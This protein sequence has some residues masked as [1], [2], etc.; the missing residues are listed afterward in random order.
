MGHQEVNSG[1]RYGRSCWW[2]KFPE[3]KVGKANS[4]SKNGLR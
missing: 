1:D 3:E 2:S 4:N